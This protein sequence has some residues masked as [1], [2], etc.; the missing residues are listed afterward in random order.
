[1]E[2][3]RPMQNTKAIKKRNFHTKKQEWAETCNNFFELE[4][5]ER[6]TF[7]EYMAIAF[8][9]LVTIVGL[10][11]FMRIIGFLKELIIAF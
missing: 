1:M 5:E 2:K 9:A 8:F 3:V 11:G 6:M 7:G 4:G 10:V